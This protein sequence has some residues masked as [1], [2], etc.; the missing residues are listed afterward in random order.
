MKKLSLSL[1]PSKGLDGGPL[2]CVLSLYLCDL[3]YCQS[4]IWVFWKGYVSRINFQDVPLNRKHAHVA[5]YGDPIAP[6]LPG[7]CGPFAGSASIMRVH[8]QGSFRSNAAGR[9]FP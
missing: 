4:M 9:P 5:N 3:I 8:A 7:I 6:L 1:L 2:K